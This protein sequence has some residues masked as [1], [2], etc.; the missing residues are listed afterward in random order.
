MLN[1]SMQ[2]PKMLED[3]IKLIINGGKVK[4]IDIQSI[5]YLTTK[6][7]PFIKKTEVHGG[8]NREKVMQG[9]RALMT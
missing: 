3:S 4:R 1:F 9:C 5:M 8:H 7:G 2:K 6:V